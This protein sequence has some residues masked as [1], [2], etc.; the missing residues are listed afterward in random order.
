M[1]Q[2]PSFTLADQAEIRRVIAA[3]PWATIT[4]STADGLV[5]SH[6]AVLLDDASDDLTV[7][8]HV[9]RPDD[10]IHGLGDGEISA[11]VGI[12]VTEGDP[13]ELHNEADAALLAAKR[14]RSPTPR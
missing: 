11:S 14:A 10:L 5:A 12:G 2:N 3:N 9:G 8:G 1:R 7:V 13:L 6:Y 4:S